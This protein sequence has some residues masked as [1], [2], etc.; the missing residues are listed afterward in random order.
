MLDLHK[1]VKLAHQLWDVKKK[2]QTALDLIEVLRT[3]ECPQCGW[4]TQKDPDDL[5]EESD[6]ETEDQESESEEVAAEEFEGDED[7]E[8]DGTQNENEE[9]TGLIEY[10][11]DEEDEEDEEK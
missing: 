10:E 11:E 5:E 4:P 6:D 7:L 1:A 3:R 2:L 8:E 9:E